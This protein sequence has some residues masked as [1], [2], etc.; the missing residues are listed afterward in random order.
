MGHLRSVSS[1]V[2]LTMSS[3]MWVMFTTGWFAYGILQ[4]R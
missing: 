2:N 1:S 4:E 3:V